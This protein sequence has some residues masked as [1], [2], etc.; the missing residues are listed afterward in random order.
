[1]TTS[2]QLT[3]ASVANIPVDDVIAIRIEGH[4]LAVYN[5]DGTFY[6][7]DD[8]CNHGNAKL[9]EGFLDGDVIEC[10]LHGGC[11]KVTNGEPCASPVTQPMKMYSV[12]VEGGEIIL[13]DPS[14]LDA[15]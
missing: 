14:E 4:D 15:S 12:K 9:S 2:N 8:R 10:P 13:T 5:V 3:L 11:F 7:S 1:M 6:V